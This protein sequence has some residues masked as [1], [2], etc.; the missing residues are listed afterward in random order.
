MM[1][2]YMTVNYMASSYIA[3]YQL[4]ALKYVHKKAAHS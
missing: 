1:M 2:S 4:I 3:I